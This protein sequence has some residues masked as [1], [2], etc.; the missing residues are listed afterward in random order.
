MFGRSQSAQ[1][2]SGSF[3]FCGAQSL[4]IPGECCGGQRRQSPLHETLSA[5]HL[6]V[7][8]LPT[9]EY[10]AMRKEMSDA[11]ITGGTSSH[12]LGLHSLSENHF[13]P[14]VGS[15]YPGSAPLESSS[16]IGSHVELIGCNGEVIDILTPPP[17]PRIDSRAPSE[18]E[19]SKRNCS[20]S[21]TI[22]DE[23]LI[24]NAFDP[25]PHWEMPEWESEPESDLDEPLP[26]EAT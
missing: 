10:C 1:K 16:C 5:E 6:V 2:K 11:Y 18:T 13:A 12:D 7:K 17:T 4:Q 22:C 3:P 20:T 26:V 21:C 25:G 14:A 24:L 23:T 15:S 9:R 8:L 19:K